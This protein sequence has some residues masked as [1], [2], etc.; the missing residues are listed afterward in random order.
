M[1]V[2]A[3]T[4][5]ARLNER[6]TVFKG[7]GSSDRGTILGIGSWRVAEDDQSCG[8]ATNRLVRLWDTRAVSNKTARS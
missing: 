3:S 6:K 2:R 8:Q 5:D 7:I 1:R 4:K